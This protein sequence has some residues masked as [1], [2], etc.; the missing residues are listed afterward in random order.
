[1]REHGPNAAETARRGPT[2]EAIV[3]QARNP[4]AWLLLFAA[5]ISAAV[6]EWRDALV[7]VT[8]LLL[9]SVLGVVQ[10]RRAGRAVEA[11]RA[12]IAARAR[13]LRDGVETQIAA[14]EVVPGDVVVLSAGSL[15]P[16]DGALLDARDLFASQAALTGETLPAEKRVGVVAADATPA[17]RANVVFQGTNIRSGTARALVL[18]TGCSTEYGALAGRLVL[19]PPETDFDRGIRRFGYLLTR[20]MLVLVIVVFAGGM[21]RHKPVAA[22]LL[23]A[24]ALAVGL[25][26]EM[27]PAIL[28]VMLSH[29]ARAMAA[30]GVVVR[31]LSAIENLGSM[32]VLC[33]DK[34]GT[35]TEGAVALERAVDADGADANRVLR[36]AWWN[37]A[38]ETGLS[39]PLDDALRERGSSEALG[40]LPTK[41]DEV[42]Y[43][44]LRKRMSVVAQDAQCRALMVT[45][46]AVECVLAVCARVGGRAGETPLDDTV[47]AALRARS[48]AWGAKGVRVLG[49]ATR[50][51][52]EGRA[53][54]ADDEQA[55]TF[56]GFLL[57]TDPPKAGVGAVVRDLAALGVGLKVVTGDRRD[58]ALH[59]ASAIG[60]TVEGSLDGR[61][62]AAMSDEALWH[63]AERTT[64]F[65]EVDPHQKERIILAL[66]KTGHVV[67]Y[68]GDGI[69]DA[70]ALHAADVGVSVDTAVDVAREAADFVLLR[71]DLGTL[72]AGVEEGRATFANTL[73]YLL[74]TESANLGNMLSMA[75]ASIV[76]PFL[77]MLASQVLL[78]NFLSDVPAMALATDR[79]DP[80]L[81]ARPQHWDLTFIRRFM[82]LFGL[83]STAF[84]A[85]T[86]ALLLGV[87]HVTPAA[88]R[89]GWFVA[90]LATELLVALVVRTRRPFWRS[91]PGRLLLGSTAAVTVIGLVLPY[92]PLGA[93]FSLVR[94]PLGTMA[95][96]V[97]VAVAYAITVEALKQRFF[98]R[99]AGR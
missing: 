1:M 25:A 51:V 58:V 24:I 6:G 76:L 95:L 68:M 72:R 82:V 12:R 11:L 96:L 52:P 60:L 94:L 35:L 5:V 26:P 97:A 7:V 16:A 47:R 87:L 10:E 30:R 14:A 8:I 85:L 4:L 48:D 49:V 41:L 34:T 22:S 42:P 37:A 74:T 46:G 75:G 83:V 93:T 56:E 27:L 2:L 20:V 3:S 23:F 33:T 55:M 80:E 79:V 78:N 38:L 67:G 17:A 29:A 69:N 92:S 88:F 39:N 45:K 53:V 61:E 71:Q 44:F 15:V 57:F 70:P 73:K 90:S 18:R 77:P 91:T 13:V 62:L 36:L 65:A 59:V 54:S 63:A 86:F 84:D 19:R 64:V 43:D 31:R 40:P 99:L 98:A 9:G 66:R 50:V 81:V 21:L 89:T 28:G 32:D